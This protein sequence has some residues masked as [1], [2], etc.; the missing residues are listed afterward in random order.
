MQ[1]LFEISL[2]LAAEEA[3][4]EVLGPPVSASWGEKSWPGT[5]GTSCMTGASAS[6]SS[7]SSGLSTL[8]SFFGVKVVF[9]GETA[10][11]GDP[12][13]AAAAADEVEGWVSRSIEEKLR[14]A[15]GYGLSAAY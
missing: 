7:S 10:A 2:G 14:E 3:A 8:G 13:A 11:D 12:T 9:E 1:K 5:T 15:A 4:A 6:S